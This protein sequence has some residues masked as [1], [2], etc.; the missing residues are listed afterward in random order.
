[1]R[2]ASKL[3][4]SG[5]PPVLPGDQ[6][7]AEAGAEEVIT[8]EDLVVSQQIL[9]KQ[10]DSPDRE[11]LMQKHNERRARLERIQHTVRP[12]TPPPMKK[13][14]EDDAGL[15]SESA[16]ADSEVRAQLVGLAANTHPH[17]T[18]RMTSLLLSSKLTRNCTYYS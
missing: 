12:D 18:N 15:T 1:M 10:F 9:M 3:F 2:S 6:T 8:A 17:T 14:T 16:A 11:R 13:A 5:L 4:S 7:V